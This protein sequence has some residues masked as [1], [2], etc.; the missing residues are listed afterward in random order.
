MYHTS[1]VTLTE[2]LGE[3]FYRFTEVNMDAATVCAFS[4][5]SQL[6]TH[7][8]LHFAVAVVTAACFCLRWSAL[9]LSFQDV[10][11]TSSVQQFSVACS[12]SDAGR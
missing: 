5:C 10:L 1:R 4:D 2:G 12:G 9:Y 6:F 8:L 3:D 11:D 7:K